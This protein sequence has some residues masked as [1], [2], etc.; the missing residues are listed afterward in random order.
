M[1]FNHCT[2]SRSKPLS[3]HCQS[4]TLDTQDADI[5]LIVSETQADITNA[6]DEI[7]PETQII[8]AKRER[9]ITAVRDAGRPHLADL[10][11]RLAVLG[12]PILATHMK[13][14]WRHSSGIRGSVE[15]Y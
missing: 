3:V 1:V 7:R 5:A 14:R 10:Q 11:H 15:T 6:E 8:I 12:S 4:S 9:R 2:T 13:S